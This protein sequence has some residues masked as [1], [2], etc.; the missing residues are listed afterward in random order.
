MGFYNTAHVKHFEKIFRPA[1]DQ[2]LTI[3]Q[4][5]NIKDSP[6][7][8][9]LQDPKFLQAIGH[10]SAKFQLYF[11]NPQ[12]ARDFVLGLVQIGVT[13][14]NDCTS[15]KP[16]LPRNMVTLSSKEVDILNYHFSVGIENFNRVYE[17]CYCPQ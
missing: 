4:N 3:G 17:A 7:G 6:L 1:M 11:K 16:V 9:F 5:P 10:Q 8:W 14:Q 12:A 2:A 13:G 15:A